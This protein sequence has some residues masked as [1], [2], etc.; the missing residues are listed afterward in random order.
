MDKYIPEQ[1]EKKWQEY[2]DSKRLF[3]VKE[4]KDKP[5]YY[6]LEMFPYPSGR[7]HMGHVRN[8]TIGDVIARYK[9]MRGYNVLHPIGWDAFGLPAEN[10]AI[11]HNTHPAKWTYNNIEYMKNQLKKLGLSYD[12]TRE[13]T[14]CLPEY[15][16]WEQ[17]LFIKMLEKGL[18]YRKKSF[19]NWCPKCET[20]LANE[21]VVDGSCWRC[22]TPVVLKELTQWFFKITEY[23]EE[24][25]EWCDRLKGWPERVISMQKNWI[26]KSEGA[27]IDFLLDGLEGKLS[28][29]TTRPDTLYGVTFVSV[30]PEHPIVDTLCRGTEQEATV[31]KF[32]SEILS[33]DTRSRFMTQSKRGVFT[34]RYCIN[35]VNGNRVP[36]Y[37]A[38]YVLMEYGTGIVMGVPAHDQRDFEFAKENNLPI[39]VVINPPGKNLNPAEMG[40]AYTEDGIMVNSSEFNNL[41]SSECK[42]K[43][44]E[45]LSRLGKG[46]KKI[47]YKL[48]DWGISRQ[49]YWGAPIPVIYCDKCGMLPVN[50]KDLPVVLPENVDLS[51]G[52][53]PLKKN[54]NFYKTKCY[55]CGSPAV[56][57][58]DTMD[59]FVESSWY[60][61]R[62]T[63]P[64][65]KRGIVNSKKAE[66]WLPVDQYIGGIEHAILHL[67]Y[68]RFYTKVLRDLGLLAIDEP[69][70]NLLTQGMVI[71]DGA[72]M[73]K[74][75]GNVV[76]PD[77]M[78][79]KYGADTTR[80]FILFAAPPERDLEW[81]DQGVEGS[82]RF[83]N[84]VWRLV[85]DLT[86]VIKR[87]KKTI[88]YSHVDGI[89]KEILKRTHITIK[90]VTE[91]IEDGFHFNTAISAL[92]EFVNFLSGI[93][94]DGTNEDRNLYAVL[95]D[96]VE[97]LLILLSPFTPHI[98]EE[99]WAQL[100]NQ[101][102]IINEKWPEWDSALI[103]AEEIEVIVQINGKVRSKIV[104]DANIS[105]NELKQKA[106]EIERVKTYTA[107]RSIKKI[108]VVPGRLVNIVL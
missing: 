103:K 51:P 9:M 29:F 67:L 43:I 56:R 23:A 27:E 60:F 75:K 71:K 52:E 74:S 70:I 39:I 8:Y 91:D 35:P 85:N 21:Q 106:L 61:A 33:R 102:S 16:K 101:K 76:D 7:I 40:E 18:A 68:A 25:L 41:L 84:R 69:F 30:A 65:Y 5:K 37:V 72:K 26:G 90:R 107:N 34:G 36:V 28:V 2:W 105:E 48:K 81:S 83:L 92:M 19:V 95:R 99:L 96:A 87:E 12:W 49:R 73:S 80:L 31:K 93:N 89:S 38:E 104:V 77:D 88:N 58:T 32:I 98:A 63:S 57:E 54:D 10:A 50:E 64:D 3:I 47:S 82:N 55:K 14:T 6:C 15:Y 4:D 17:W 45:K 22:E 13:V 66:Y 24:L 100:G 59:T 11:E 79:K 86:P 62:Y 97:K 46:R 53:S 94:I 108:I 42:A 44:V 20:V 78:I 1:I